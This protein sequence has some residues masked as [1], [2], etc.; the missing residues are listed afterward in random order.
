MKK[1]LRVNGSIFAVA[2]SSMLI[3]FLTYGTRRRR[4]ALEARSKE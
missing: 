1:L 3:T 2:A 4:R